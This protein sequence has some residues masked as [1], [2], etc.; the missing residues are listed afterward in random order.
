MN[1]LSEN[2]LNEF[3]DNEIAEETRLEV[4]AHISGC[5]ECRKRM[6]ELRALFVELTQLSDESP[7]CDL[8]ALAL[9]RLPRSGLSRKARLALAVQA[10]AALGFLIGIFKYAFGFILAMTTNWHIMKEWERLSNP[11]SIKLPIIE[12]PS[13]E[14]PA[15]RMPIPVP[16]LVVMLIIVVAFWWRGNTRLLQNGS[17][18]QT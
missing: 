3:L 13:I 18:Y 2:L 10:G 5:L 1:H 16:I 9:R 11:M 4:E 14:F 6:E 12:L 17:E 8:S 7:T 15:Y